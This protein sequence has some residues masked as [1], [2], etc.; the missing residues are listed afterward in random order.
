[1]TDR[2]PVVTLDRV[3]ASYGANGALRDW[4]IA[5]PAGAV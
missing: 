4:T 3:T 2:E 5:C 1:M